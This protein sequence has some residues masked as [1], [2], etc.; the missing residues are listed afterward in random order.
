ML[1]KS[2]EG[3]RRDINPTN[4]YRRMGQ[5]FAELRPVGSDRRWYNFLLIIDRG[6]KIKPLMKGQRK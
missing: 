6:E 1:G 4:E 5:E 2:N 3:V